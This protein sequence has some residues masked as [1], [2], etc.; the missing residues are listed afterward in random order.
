[1]RNPIHLT[2]LVATILLI[3]GCGGNDTPASQS[4]KPTIRNA[5]PEEHWTEQQ[6]MDA[7]GLTT[8]DGGITYQTASG[9]SASVVLTNKSAVEVYAGAGDTVVTNPA[10]TAGVKTSANEPGCLAEFERGLAAL[11]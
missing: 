7:A 5:E 1:M 6:V 11:K 3:G 9:C 8:E 10:G 2:V 4:A